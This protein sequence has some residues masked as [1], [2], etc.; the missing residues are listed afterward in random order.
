MSDQADMLAMVRNFSRYVAF[1]S[2]IGI[3][4]TEVSPGHVILQVPF[5]PEL[6]GDPIRPA[7][8]GGVTATLIDSAS[9]A[10]VWT[11]VTLYDRISTI[12]MRVDYL[13]PAR[14]ETL[15]AEARVLRKGNHVAVA[16]ARVYHPSTP[17]E[18]VAEGKAVFSIRRAG[19]LPVPTGTPSASEG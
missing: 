16:S 2:F 14:L 6:I 13:L 15:C 17:N 9:G 3:E 11:L 19:K 10:A 12:D 5:K 18:T 4:P 8:H 1:N 7:L